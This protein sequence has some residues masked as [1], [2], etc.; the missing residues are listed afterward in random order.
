MSTAPPKATSATPADRLLDRRHAAVTV[1]AVARITF[2]AFESL[3]VA[4][5][6]PAVADALAGLTLYALA[7]G[8][9]LATAIIAMVLSGSWND[10]QGP[11]GR[12]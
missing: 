1:G 2:L 11:P 4:T 3:G 7:F 8:S 6:M 10:A 12:S 9:P 5:A